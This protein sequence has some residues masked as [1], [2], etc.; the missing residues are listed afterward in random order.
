[1]P[2]AELA[3]G[4]LRRDD[5]IAEVEA[6][7]VLPAVFHGV[8]RAEAERLAGVHDLVPRP[9][10]AGDGAAGAPHR[11]T[12]HRFHTRRRLHE[13]HPVPAVRDHRHDRAPFDRRHIRRLE[14]LAAID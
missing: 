12:R 6:V 4:E 2:A 3:R 11:L 7:E 1:M 5:E 10:Q 8:R 9:R 14:R 13:D